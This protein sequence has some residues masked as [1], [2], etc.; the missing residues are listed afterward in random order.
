M[1]VPITPTLAI[2]PVKPHGSSDV[3]AEERSSAIDFVNRNN[4]IMEQFQHGTVTGVDEMRAF[5]N[6]TYPYIIP[7]VSRH[8][9]NHIVDRDE[10][11]GGVTVRYHEQ[12]I[13]YAWPSVFETQLKGKEG[14]FIESDGDL[15]QIWIYN[16]H[17]DRL[18]MTETGWKLRERVLG[19][20]VVNPQMDPKN[21]PKP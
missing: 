16:I 5:F 10:E 18:V 2:P 12:C 11:T 9:T 14:S 21:E 19:P 20:A 8:A 7:G 13:R 1:S 15:P 17:Y 3:T 4:L 6:T